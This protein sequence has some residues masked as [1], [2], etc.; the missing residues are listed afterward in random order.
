MALDILDSTL[1][2]LSDNW[3]SSNTNDLT[4]KFQKVTDQKRMDFN[5]NQDWILGHRITEVTEPAGTGPADKNEFSNFNLDVRVFGSDQEAHFLNVLGEI[6]RI[7]KEQ[8]LAPFVSSISDA[9]VIE[10][11]GS[12][13]DLSNKMHHVWRKLI[14]V[15][16]KRYN[17]SR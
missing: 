16:V 11:D 13:P 17:V 9:H 5:I 15:Q 2:L 8:K 4:P 10:W 12:G 6:K 7:L 3:D 14:P 1:T